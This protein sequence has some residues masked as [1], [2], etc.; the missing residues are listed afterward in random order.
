M[1]PTTWGHRKLALGAARVGRGWMC[2][3]KVLLGG[4]RHWPS[5][6]GGSVDDKVAP[7]GKSGWMPRTPGCTTRQDRATPEGA[8]SAGLPL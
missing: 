5:L 6:V 7:Q 2:G 8:W 3:R 1:T 4:C